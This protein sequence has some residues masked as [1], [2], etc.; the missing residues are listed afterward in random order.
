MKRFWITLIS[1]S[2]LLISCSKNK[3]NITTDKVQVRIEN[4]TGFTLE[5]A[6]VGNINYGNLIHGQ[7][8]DYKILD[9]PIYAGYCMFEVDNIQSFAGVGVCGSPL[10]PSFEPG[11]Y[12]FKVIPTVNGYNTVAVIKK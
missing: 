4:L 11:Y 10:P 12:T 9:Q 1:F 2:A 6:T 3:T 8:T 7:L 5:N